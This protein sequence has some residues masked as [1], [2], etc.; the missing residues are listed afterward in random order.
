MRLVSL[1]ELPHWLAG[2]E[3]LD[4]AN[5]VDMSSHGNHWMRADE[6]QSRAMGRSRNEIGTSMTMASLLPCLSPQRTCSQLLTV[7][8]LNDQ[9]SRH[10]L[11]SHFYGFIIQLVRSSF[12]CGKKVLAKKQVVKKLPSSEKIHLKYESTRRKPDWPLMKDKAGS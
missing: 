6:F 10:L 8:S 2:K 12:D 9:L 7:S 3:W 4:I 5:H 1:T 11:N